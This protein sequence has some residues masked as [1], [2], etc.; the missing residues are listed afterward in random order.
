MIVRVAW[1]VALAVLG[2]GGIAAEEAVAPVD[3]TNAVV[4][5]PADLSA[6]ERVAVDLLLDEVEKRTGVRWT[7]GQAWPEGP[8]PVVAVGPAASAAA[9]AGPFAGKL[10]EV[11]G[12]EGYVIRTAHGLRAQPITDRS[13]VLV[14]GADERGVLFGVGRL[15]RELRMEKGKALLPAI[16]AATAPQYPLRGHQ[17]GYRPKTN[18][19][20]AWD[21][22]TWEQYIRDLAVFGT[23]AIELIPPRSDDAPTSPHFPLPQIE[24]MAHQSR[25]ADELGLDVWIWYPAM[26]KDYSNPETVEFALKEWGEVFAKLPRIDAIFV[27]GGDPGHTQPKHLM[28]LL[29]KET[30]VLHRTHPNAQMWVSPQSF[31]E[32]WLNEFLEI[33]T[34][35]QPKWLS[36]IVYG[37]QNRNDLAN[38]RSRVPEQYP[39]RHYPDITHTIRCQFPVPEWDLAYVLTE[40]REPINPRPLDYTNIFRQLSPMT[41][42]FITYSEGCND[43]VNKIVWSGLG[44][45]SNQP[46][47]QLLREYA[48]YFIGPQYEEGWA[49]GLMALEQNWRGPLLTNQGVF[50]TLSQFQ[51]MERAASPETRKNWR[52]QQAMYRAYYDAYNATRLAYENGLEQEALGVLRQAGELGPKKAMKQAEKILDRAEEEPVAQDLRARVFEYADALYQSIRMQLSVPLYK[53]I[54]V[55]RG[56]NLDLIDTPLNNRAWLKERFEAIRAL[57]GDQ[58]Q[59]QAL[60]ALVDWS[61]PGPGGFYDDLGNTAQQ[62]HLVT[63]LNEGYDA[64]NPREYFSSPMWK[65]D[66]EFRISPLVGFQYRKTWRTSWMRHAEARYDIPLALRYEGLDPA[67]RYKVRV[68]YA[69][70]KYDTKVHL[71]ADSAVKDYRVDSSTGYEVHP[72]IE[73][74]QPDAPVEYDVPREATADGTLTLLFEQEP[75][76]GGGGRGAQVAEVWL[77]RK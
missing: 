8:A 46:A 42:G 25:I 33:L 35:Q 51:D 9:F 43:D 52:F 77:I 47:V 59:L 57:P 3:F 22:P 53:A 44:W 16:D 73:K 23:N 2:A 55:G 64:G 1:T 13:A 28:A 26:D 60:A 20:D 67:A 74:P 7:E 34:T 30:E 11:P 66:P 39:I 50:T 38:L 5:T 69:G 58:E 29:E 37:P 19:Y 4:V 56:A 48:R 76:R 31:G 72:W 15:L 71:A 24:M 62:P 36:G 68:A 49:Q 75:G 41:N 6:R 17:M 18:S 27:P 70:D 10:G 12:R 45:D 61:N 65:H 32:E 54:E 40:Q 14:A 21:V 63:R